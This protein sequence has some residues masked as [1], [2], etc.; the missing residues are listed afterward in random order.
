VTRVDISSEYALVKAALFPVPFALMLLYLVWKA[1]NGEISSVV[2]GLPADFPEWGRWLILVGLGGVISYAC[3]Q[4]A[5]V[6][7]LTLID[8][9]LLIRSLTASA[10]VP[11]SQVESIQ[12]TQRPE[13]SDTAEAMIVLGVPTAVGTH[14]VFEPKSAE[15]FE[16]LRSKVEGR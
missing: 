9:Q 7:Q 15:A 2:V 11:L 1:L 8:D 13:N 6:K 5:T 14:I 3:W 16:L 12:W 4:W 10:R